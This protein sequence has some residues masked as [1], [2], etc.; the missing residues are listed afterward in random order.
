MATLTELNVNE[1][2]LKHHVR[3]NVRHNTKENA[4]GQTAAQVKSETRHRILISAE[5]TLAHSL[6]PEQLPGVAK[7]EPGWSR[8]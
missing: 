2:S 7:P 5:G 4:P 6:G 3:W 1:S 8:T